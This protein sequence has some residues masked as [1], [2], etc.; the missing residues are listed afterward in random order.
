[1]GKDAAPGEYDDTHHVA[2]DGSDVGSVEDENDDENHDAEHSTELP[3]KPPPTMDVTVH[4]LRHLNFHPKPILCLASTPAPFVDGGALVALSRDNGA[5]E[6]KQAKKLRTIA[7]VAGFRQKPV[8]AM[9]WLLAPAEDDPARSSAPSLPPLIGA[10]RDGT[11]FCVDF[12]RQC[13]TDITPS[14]GGGVFALTTK[15]RRRDPS[16]VRSEDRHLFAVGCEDGAARIWKYSTRASGERSSR[17]SVVSSLPTAG[18]PIL[19]IAWCS[20][21]L[22]GG[23]KLFAAV[24]DGT[25]RIFDESLEAPLRWSAT[26]RMTVE[27]LGRTIPTRVWALEVLRDGTLVSADSLGHVQ[28]WD[29]ATGTLQQ[30]IDQ[31][32]S[33]ADVLCLAVSDDETTIFASGVDSRVICIERLAVGSQAHTEDNFGP[34]QQWA[35][36]HAQRPHTHDVNALIIFRQVPRSTL[37]P[38]EERTADIHETLCSGGVDTKLCT[39]PVRD[40]RKKRPKTLYPWPANLISLARKLRVFAVMREGSID[41]YQLGSK[42]SLDE[43]FPIQIPP[44]K[45]L[46]GTVQVEGVSNVACSAM[47]DDGRYLAFSD[48]SSVSLF[49]LKFEMDGDSVASMLQPKRIAI[50]TGSSIAASS[51]CFHASGNDLVCACFDGRLVFLAIEE[52]LEEEEPVVRVKQVLNA[53]G[54]EARNPSAHSVFMTHDGNFLA[55]MHC[56]PVGRIEIYRASSEATYTHWWTVPTSEMTPSAS[57]FLLTDQPLLAVACLNFCVYV[58]DVHEK[59]LSPWSDAAGYPIRDLP[60]EFGHRNDYPVHIAFNPAARN[61]FLVVRLDCAHLLQGSYSGAPAL[62]HVAHWVV[63]LAKSPRLSRDLVSPL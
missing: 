55:T 10:S 27:S 58:F 45:T 34:I 26:M 3:S 13:L 22:A 32:D 36:S 21:A 49:R 54:V 61:K 52:R 42:Q 60:A 35:L 57:A 17:L 24:A 46:L 28:F 4:R 12:V 5:V 41:V 51:L 20:N 15:H 39:Y 16:T 47:S 9:A 7:T 48:A 6:L 62:G 44:D 63:T 18:A 33:K 43:N 11:I 29:G 1:M 50:E 56:A 23:S 2:V 8:N 59:K 40:G 19:S 30:S 25:I 53:N 38:A 37:A 14:G 31:N